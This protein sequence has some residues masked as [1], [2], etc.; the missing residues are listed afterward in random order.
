[1]K[2]S[3]TRCSYCTTQISFAATDLFQVDGFA[4]LVCPI[5]GVAQITEVHCHDWHLVH[6]SH[7]HWLCWKWIGLHHNVSEQLFTVRSSCSDATNPQDSA[8]K[9]YF[10]RGTLRGALLSDLTSGLDWQQSLVLADATIYAPPNTSFAYEQGVSFHQQLLIASGLRELVVAS[11]GQFPQSFF[12]QRPVNSAVAGSHWDGINNH[13]ELVYAHTGRNLGWLSFQLITERGNF[14]FGV[15]GEDDVHGVG[16]LSQLCQRFL[17]YNAGQIA[18]CT[19]CQSYTP[20]YGEYAGRS[21]G[22]HGWSHHRCGSVDVWHCPNDR[23][24]ARHCKRCGQVRQP[25]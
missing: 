7:K 9:T 15:L 24:D 10:D 25:F 14:F 22:K 3:Q 16:P 5:C 19:R 11:G 13:A 20:F 6:L 4:V 12:E 21:S 18:K 23:A 8:R 1:M 17:A 2:R